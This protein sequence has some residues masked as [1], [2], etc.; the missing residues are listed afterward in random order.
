MHRTIPLFL[1]LLLLPL[2][3]LAAKDAKRP[4][5][6]TLRSKE[7][8]EL[9]ALF[10]RYV[11]VG[12]ADRPGLLAEVEKRDPLPD[13]AVKELAKKPFEMARKNGPRVAMSSASAL[14][15]SIAERND[16]NMYFT[17]RVPLEPK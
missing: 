11:E 3:P 15:L 8:R 2:A 13:S 6:P 7:K 10:E 17:M 5:L 9:L 16:R 1:L 12:D 4:R 14:L